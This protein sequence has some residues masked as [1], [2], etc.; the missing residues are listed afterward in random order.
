M[1]EQSGWMPLFPILF[2]DNPC[3]NGNHSAA[4][5]ADAY[6]KGI[7]NFDIQKAY[8]GIKKNAMEATMLPWRNGPM[9]SL[10]TFYLKNG[11]YPALNPGEKETVALVHPFEKRQAVALTLGQSYDDWCLARLAKALDKNDDYEYFLKRSHN[12][13]NLY[14]QETGFFAPRTSDG[15]WV[16]DFDP[17]FSG[18]LGNRDY[19]DENNGWTYLWDVQ[20]DISGLIGLMGGRDEFV[21]RLNQ[22]FIEPLGKWKPDYLQQMPDATGQVGQFVMGNEPSLHIPYLYNYAGAPWRTQQRVRMLLDTWFTNSPFGMP[23]DEDGGG[24]SAFVVF[25]S[26]G[27]YPVTPGLPVFNIGSPVFTDISIKLQNNKTFRILARGSSSKNKYIQKAKLNGKDWNK[28]W[29][30]WDD[31][32]NGGVMELDM[33]SRPD[34]NW[35]SGPADAPPSKLPD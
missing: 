13:A 12:Y 29:F 7:R 1:Y 19:Y 28:P 23:G 20:H 35:G 32:K 16:K 24:L 14:N 6:F 21:N 9:C 27:F 25:S 11:Y 5:I 2:G 15:N 33:S 34:Y 10:D 3:M 17:K 31:I 22:L 26:M 30:L 8:E 18:G 4:I